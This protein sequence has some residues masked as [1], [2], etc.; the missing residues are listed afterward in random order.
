MSNAD[1]IQL[2]E[3]LAEALQ[4]DGYDVFP[5]WRCK[6]TWPGAPTDIVICAR[7][8]W[9]R[10]RIG[11]WLCEHNIRWTHT[12]QEKFVTA[13]TPDLLELF[14]RQPTLSTEIGPLFTMEATP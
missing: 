7:A 4:I 2:T 1:I 12:S 5:D 10:H 6:P 13:C 11:G 9:R 8:A 3:W 14:A